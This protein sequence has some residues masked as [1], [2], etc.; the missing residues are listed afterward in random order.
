MIKTNNFY[1][2]EFSPRLNTIMSAI[3]KIEC[4]AY[5]APLIFQHGK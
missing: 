5:L 4:V 2:K 3:G 1:F